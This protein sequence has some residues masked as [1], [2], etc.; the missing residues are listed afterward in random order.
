MAITK[1]IR[2]RDINIYV[3][4][5]SEFVF[6][7]CATN[8]TYERTAEEIVI[9]TADSGIED[10]YEGGATNATGTMDGVITTDALGGW[11]YEDWLDCVGQKKNI[12][13]DF[14]NDYG[15]LL[16]FEMLVLITNV[17]A[18]GDANDF[19]SFSV[20]FKRSGAE[21][22]TK[23]IEGGILDSNLDY[24]LDGNGVIIR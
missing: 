23:T 8:M 1:I 10:E 6:T 2:G 19:G 7:A 22:V 3:E 17:S 18:Q 21:T 20:G 15:D 13:I 9:T 24:I 12:M 5:G 4:R 16:R 14:T 11:Q